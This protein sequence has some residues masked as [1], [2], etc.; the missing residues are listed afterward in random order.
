MGHV[1][2]PKTLAYLADHPIVRTRRLGRGIGRQ[3]KTSVSASAGDTG[4][5]SIQTYLTARRKFLPFGKNTLVIVYIIL[6]TMLC[7]DDTVSHRTVGREAQDRLV[8]TD[9]F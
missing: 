9:W 4:L 2:L 6:P 8:G 3:G 7:P 5:F 1:K